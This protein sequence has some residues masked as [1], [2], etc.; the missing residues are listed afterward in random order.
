MKEGML[1]RKATVAACIAALMLALLAAC[2]AAETTQ[3]PA[4]E[5]TI[6]ESAEGRVV[7]MT[8]GEAE[9]Y[10]T[11]N[12]SQAAA[13]LAQMLPL[14]MDLIERAYFAKGMFLP[15]PLPDTEQT[16]REYAVGDLGYWAEGQNLALFYDDWMPQTSV[17]VISLGHAESGAEQLA[18]LTGTATLELMPDDAYESQLTDHN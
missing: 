12:D 4:P 3:A 17:P 11:L 14:E 16:T 10:I 5:D 15:S 6:L 18:G 1:M 7:K 9:I 8:A 2:G 13:A